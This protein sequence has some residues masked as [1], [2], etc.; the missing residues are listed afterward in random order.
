MAQV[1][2]AP[3]WTL[4]G[5]GAF[6]HWSGNGNLLTASYP[7]GRTWFAAGKDHVHASPANLTAYVIG[8][9]AP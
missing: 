3:G 1:T 4:S 9:L 8:I 7:V 6:D 2:L 5:G